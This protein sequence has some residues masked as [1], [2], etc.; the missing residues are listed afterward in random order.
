MRISPRISEAIL[1]Q[2]EVLVDADS[3]ILTPPFHAETCQTSS[4]ALRWTGALR[5]VPGVTASTSGPGVPTTPISC[6]PEQVAAAALD[7]GLHAL[8]M[9]IGLGLLAVL[10][11]P[12]R[13]GRFSAAYHTPVEVGGLYWHFVDVVL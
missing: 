1:P 7:S 5:T 13:R 11:V 3:L 10:A 6:S 8:H 9:V 12:T 4:Q 2:L